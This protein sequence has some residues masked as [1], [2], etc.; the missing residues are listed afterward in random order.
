MK[1]PPSEGLTSGP[2]SPLSL[3]VVKLFV[4]LCYAGLVSRDTVEGVDVHTELYCEG[5]SQE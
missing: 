2:Q 3:E 4:I 1:E 5:I